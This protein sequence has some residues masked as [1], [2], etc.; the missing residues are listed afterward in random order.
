MLP[1][2]HER[3]SDIAMELVSIATNPA[4]EDLREDMVT[5]VVQTNLIPRSV[6][7]HALA[8]LTIQYLCVTVGVLAD[9]VAG[10]VTNE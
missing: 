3:A 9:E 5:R 4:Y 10:G 8:L 1:N 2:L 6:E 7:S